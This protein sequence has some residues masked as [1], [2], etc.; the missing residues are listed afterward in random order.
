MNADGT[1]QVRLTIFAGQDTKPT[2]SPNGDRIALH[3]RI[4]G[5]LEVFTM[6]GDGTDELRLTTTPT[7]GVS[8]FPSWGNW[9]AKLR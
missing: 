3:R 5:H 2:W 9:A 1:D 7:P 4:A 8:G 6:N